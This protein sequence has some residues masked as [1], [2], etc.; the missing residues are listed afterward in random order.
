MWQPETPTP[1]PGDNQYTDV[2]PLYPFSSSSPVQRA[3]TLFYDISADQEDRAGLP[4]LVTERIRPLQHGTTGNKD[5][6]QREGR[7]RKHRTGE[8]GMPTRVFSE[9]SNTILQGSQQSSR[10]SEKPGH[11]SVQSRPYQAWLHTFQ[12][13]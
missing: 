12:N 5:G 9:Q 1:L 8:H 13:Q 3:H 7:C 2:S 4:M 6:H 10:G 11:P